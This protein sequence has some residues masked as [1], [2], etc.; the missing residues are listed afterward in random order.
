MYYSEYYISDKFAILVHKKYE[1]SKHRES[2][3]KDFV[4]PCIVCVCVC[5]CVC[6]RAGTCS[7]VSD[8]FATPWTIAPQAPLS[9]EFSRLEVGGRLPYPPPG[10]L[11]NP[12]IKPGSHYVFCISKCILYHWAIQEA[13][14]C[15]NDN[16]SSE[17]IPPLSQ[18]LKAFI[19]KPLLIP[20]TGF[21]RHEC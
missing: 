20:F 12:G 8:S 18:M 7:V 13:H 9:M 2:V 1:I 14:A 17:R 5:V 21:L 19:S 16:F 11:F 15:R 4:H 3:L 10:D 6:A